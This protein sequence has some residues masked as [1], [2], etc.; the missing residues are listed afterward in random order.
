MLVRRCSLVDDDELALRSKAFGNG[1][2]ENTA[3]PSRK[4]SLASTPCLPPTR[5]TPAARRLSSWTHHD[6]KSR[7]GAKRPQIGSAGAVG[8]PP[9]R[10][11]TGHEP[12]GGEKTTHPCC[13]WSLGGLRKNGKC[14]RA[15]QVASTTARH[16]REC[17]V[18]DAT[19]MV[20][21]RWPRGDQRSSADG[22]RGDWRWLA[23][24]T[25]PLIFLSTFHV[26][27]NEVAQVRAGTAQR[28]PRPKFRQCRP[29]LVPA[30]TLHDAAG[31][32]PERA[33]RT[34]HGVFS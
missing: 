1:K 4:Y 18:P 34:E 9:I 8:M 28:L 16:K 6:A 14:D 24:K 22:C 32:G 10:S 17:V 27:R 13:G 12:A 11:R 7:Q 5:K 19:K 26:G 23:E 31:I 29:L 33:S 30:Y 25:Q 15:V 3:A 20:P 21:R 2:D